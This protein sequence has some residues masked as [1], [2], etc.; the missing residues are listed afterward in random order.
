MIKINRSNAKDK[1]VNNEVKT[2]LLTITECELTPT[3]LRNQSQLKKKKKVN[4]KNLVDASHTFTSQ[5]YEPA[6]VNQGY[7][8]CKAFLFSPSQLMS[9]SMQYGGRN[10][11]KFNN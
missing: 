6:R 8:I 3:L 9:F 2:K 1:S 11:I 5:Q 10:A 7:Q 4:K